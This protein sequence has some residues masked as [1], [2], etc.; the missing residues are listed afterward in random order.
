[1]LD[2]HNY[3]GWNGRL[4]QVYKSSQC[5]GDEEET[6]PTAFPLPS[7]GRGSKLFMCSHS[8]TGLLQSP[9]GSLLFA[10]HPPGFF[11]LATPNFHGRLASSFSQP[12]SLWCFLSTLCQDPVSIA[13]TCPAPL[14]RDWLS[15]ICFKSCIIK[16][17]QIYFLFD[18][19]P[20][21][22]QTSRVPFDMSLIY[23]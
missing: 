15:L 2:K 19:H 22:L 4:P 5:C 20:K 9:K 7:W 16:H 3:A 23:S 13:C 11:P 18:W 1:M 21:Y 8:L 12:R 6:H 14:C 10:L 17:R